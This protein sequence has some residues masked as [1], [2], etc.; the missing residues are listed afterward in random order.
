MRV[1][2]NQNE[3]RNSTTSDLNPVLVQDIPTQATGQENPDTGAR[4]GQ[5]VPLE[6]A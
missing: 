2:S 1:E 6:G 3:E 4:N 5:S